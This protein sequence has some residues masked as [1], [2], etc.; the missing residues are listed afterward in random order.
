[1]VQF[2]CGLKNIQI[3]KTTTREVSS[4]QNTLNDFKKS[5]PACF[6]KEETRLQ[7]K[8]GQWTLHNSTQDKRSDYYVVAGWIY[9]SWNAGDG[10]HTSWVIESLFSDNDATP[11]NTSRHAGMLNRRWRKKLWSES[12]KTHQE[13]LIFQNDVWKTHT[14]WQQSC[15]LS[16]F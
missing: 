1:M 3:K 13:F 10:N 5:N 6:R 7:S 2:N 14:T 4:I 16:K 12:L 9:S 15:R 11:W 8:T